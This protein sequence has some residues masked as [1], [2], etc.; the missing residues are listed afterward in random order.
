[1]GCPHCQSSE[2]SPDG[3]CLICGLRLAAD[4]PAQNPEAADLPAPEP[5]A[6]AEEDARSRP[7]MIEMDYSEGAQ[8]SE[9]NAEV[10]PWRQELS[11]RLHEIKQKREAIAVTH[12]ES[13]LT[14][15]VSQA[16]AAETLSALQARLLEKMPPR[17]PQ[18]PAVPPP[19]QKTLEPLQPEPPL[20][21]S[22]PPPAQPPDQREIRNLIDNAVSRQ[23]PQVSAPVVVAEDYEPGPLPDEEGKLILLSRTLSGL[24]DLIVL[25]LCTGV[26]IICADFF[27]GILVLDGVSLM[28]FSA[29][30]LLNYFLYSLFFLSA[31][32]QTIG[33]MITD[34]RLVGTGERRPTLG[35]LLVRCCIYLVSLLGLGIGL[36]LSLFD[37]DHK[38]LHDRT[39]GTHVVRI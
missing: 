30:F 9:E 13:K 26:F 35:Q 5:E 14:A 15:P 18:P 16:K 25:V 38:C 17:K 12:Q 11:Q 7:G 36:V 28:N 24:V 3:V 39:S 27:S 29:L 37:R 19:Q 2:I 4:T 23:A 32:N 22:V 6:A 8:E 21:E 10:P 31:S 1:M 20:R 34:L 33:M